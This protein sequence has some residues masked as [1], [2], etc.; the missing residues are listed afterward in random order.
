MIGSDCG[1]VIATVNMSRILNIGRIL[2]RLASSL[3]I[4]S[5]SC[6]S[7]SPGRNWQP[8]MPIRLERAETMASPVTIP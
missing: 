5:R 4:R 6:G 3:P 2:R 1:S 8:R 7:N